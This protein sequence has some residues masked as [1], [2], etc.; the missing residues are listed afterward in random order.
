LAFQPLNVGNEVGKG[1][2][3]RDIKKEISAMDH[4]DQLVSHIRSVYG[5][6]IRTTLDQVT[7][8]VTRATGDP[9]VAA[10]IQSA[11]SMR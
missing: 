2:A 4:L 10:K 3:W 8:R 6:Y 11:V 1:H 7:E 9:E 5:T